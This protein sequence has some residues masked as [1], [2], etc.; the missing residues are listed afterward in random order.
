MGTVAGGFVMGA[1]RI[2]LLKSSSWLSDSSLSFTYAAVTLTSP[3]PMSGASKLKLLQQP[4]HD[5]VQPPGA[6]VLRRL[7]HADS[8]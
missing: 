2:N 8:A 6:D 3:W 1:H 5:R 4:L 7:I